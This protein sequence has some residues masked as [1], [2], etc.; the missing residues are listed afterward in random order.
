MNL[1]LLNKLRFGVFDIDYQRSTVDDQEA[2]APS[3]RRRLEGTTIPNNQS[4]LKNW[5]F[6]DITNDEVILKLFFANPLYV[7]SN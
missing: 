1:T 7:S 4:Y 5:N 3:Q 2:G 6:V